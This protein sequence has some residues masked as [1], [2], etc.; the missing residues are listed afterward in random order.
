MSLRSLVAQATAASL[1]LS[2]WA[3]QAQSTVPNPVPE[4]EVWTLLALA[5]AVGAIVSRRRK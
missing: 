1:L 5:A 2:S 4:P 3:A